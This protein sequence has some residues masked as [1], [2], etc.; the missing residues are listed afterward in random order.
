MPLPFLKINPETK[1]ARLA[2]KT[3]KISWNSPAKI[4]LD[5]SFPPA[6]VPSLYEEQS[7]ANLF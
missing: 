6:K 2:Q 3:L 1:A 5:Y 4:A 7:A